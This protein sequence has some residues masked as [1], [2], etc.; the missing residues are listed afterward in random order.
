MTER[1]SERLTKDL[2]AE[3]LN[4]QFRFRPTPEKVLELELTEVSTKEYLRAAGMDHFSLVF[5]G[6][7]DFFL[8][9]S[10]YRVEHERMGE[11]DLFIVPI[12]RDAEGFYYQAVF[13][14][15]LEKV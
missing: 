11:F 7:A 8:P 3:N 5:R 15:M 13:N 6:P 10:T 12:R 14:R 1:V 2:F 9:Q 4:T